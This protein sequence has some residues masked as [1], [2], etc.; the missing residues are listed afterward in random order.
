[1]KVILLKDVENLGK[2]HEVK[3]IKNGHARNFLI[4]K[5]LA[6]PATPETLKWLEI[7][8][9]IATKKEEENLKGAAELV[10]KID[11]LEV[12][13]TVKTG[14]KGQLFE[15]ITAQRIS[16][17]LKEMGFEVKKD[18]IIIAEPIKEIGEFPIKVKFEHNLEA[19]IKIIITEEA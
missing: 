5:G 10:S 14:D 6:K 13:F 7:Q 9:E 11:G 16:E 4:P 15:K 18:Q 3:E 1:M 17:K 2:K 12:S 8:K 19:E